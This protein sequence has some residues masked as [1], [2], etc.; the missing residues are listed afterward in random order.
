MEKR[1]SI[2]EDYN[3][4]FTLASIKWKDRMLV[5]IEDKQ[6]SIDIKDNIELPFPMQDGKTELVAGAY[7]VELS[8]DKTNYI[9]TN[10]ETQERVVFPVDLIN[11]PTEEPPVEGEGNPDQLPGADVGSQQM[12][13]NLPQEMMFPPPTQ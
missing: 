8:P 6:Y 2:L 1:K 11:Q 10:P 5:L 9:W 4:L 7:Q 12:D 3:K 13:P